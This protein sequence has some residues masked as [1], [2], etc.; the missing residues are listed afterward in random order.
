MAHEEWRDVVGY[1][2][3]YQVSNLGRV[4]SL[5]RYIY[6]NRTRPFL[7]HGKLISCEQPN[8]KKRVALRMR[9][10]DKQVIERVYVDELVARA[11]VKNTNDGPDVIHI[12]GNVS[13]C[14]ASNLA[15][16][17]KK[18]SYVYDP[19]ADEEWK[20][21]IG[22][23][24]YYQ[25]SSQGRVK[26]LSI[27]IPSHCGTRIRKERILK[28][29]HDTHGYPKVELH[30]DGFSRQYRVHWLVASAFLPNPDNL[31]VVDHINAVRYDNRVENLRW[32]DAKENIRHSI[33]LGNMTFDHLKR[34]NLSEEARRK[35][36]ASIS[37][38]VI[39]SDGKRYASQIEAA[40]DLGY[41]SCNPIRRVALGLQQSCKGYTFRY[42]S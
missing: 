27:Q 3:C 32:V 33:E 24:G 18:L 17:T 9:R 35:N 26:S 30:K 28:A 41:S 13:N 11:F 22:F 21:V 4:R 37:K 23:E 2:G 16:G 39:R 20:D 19:N 15:W 34:E 31:P 36:D 25:V 6:S 1:E 42:I 10:N 29:S 12:D 14:Q 8:G 5:D 38:P 40:K 7:I